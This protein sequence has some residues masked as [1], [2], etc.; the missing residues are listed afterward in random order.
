MVVYCT[1]PTIMR[2]WLENDNVLPFKIGMKHAELDFV[3]TIVRDAL[4]GHY[5]LHHATREP[6]L[7][8]LASL[9][10]TLY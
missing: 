6:P 9:L 4:V 2:L 8:P 10:V 1:V 5:S 3:W 7:S